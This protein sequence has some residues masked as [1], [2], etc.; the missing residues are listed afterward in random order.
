MHKLDA[1]YLYDPLY[2]KGDFV[3][4]YKHWQGECVGEG[5]RFLPFLSLYAIYLS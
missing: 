5:F 2:L 4:V 3:S 1:R